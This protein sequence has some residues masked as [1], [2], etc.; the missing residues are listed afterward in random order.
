M[1]ELQRQHAVEKLGVELC[2]VLQNPVL[3]SLLRTAIWDSLCEIETRGDTLNA[4]YFKG[5]FLLKR[6]QPEEVEGGRS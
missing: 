3:P 2:L 4:D 6:R 5:L 1:T